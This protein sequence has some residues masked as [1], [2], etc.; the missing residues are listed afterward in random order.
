MNITQSG[1][2]EY[3][4]RNN[5]DRIATFR[6]DL[7]PAHDELKEVMLKGGVTA[8][9]ICKKIGRVENVYFE[10]KKSSTFRYDAAKHRFIY[11]E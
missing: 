8:D 2:W 5:D 6:S 10:L 7:L 3:W 1:D 11:T 4:L 9:K